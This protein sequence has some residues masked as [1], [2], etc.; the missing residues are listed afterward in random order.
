M[1]LCLAATSA[2]LA[3]SACARG[4]VRTSPSSEYEDVAGDFGVLAEPGAGMP[5]ASSYR[6]REFEDRL[7]HSAAGQFIT[8]DILAAN[9]DQSLTQVLTTHIRGFT[10]AGDSH[11]APGFASS[12]TL[13]VFVDGL[14]TGDVLTPL[15]P[16]DLIGV[17]YYEATS[18]P[19][20]YRR[21]FSSCPV[22]LL[23]L[24]P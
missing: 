13:N 16:R 7:R 15:R 23:W 9:G 20:Q 24:R 17:E 21:A 6:L 14:P 10:T 1:R 3:L 5:L 4:H 18:A 22:L 2:A 19:V 12:C 11:G 8:G